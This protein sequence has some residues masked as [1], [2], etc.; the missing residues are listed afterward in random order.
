MKFETQAYFKTMKLKES[1]TMFGLNSKMTKTVKSHFWGDKK[2]SQE[3][4]M[5]T[6][7]SNIENISHIK[8]CPMYSQLREGKDLNN[9]SDLVQ[10]FTEVLKMRENQDC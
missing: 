6:F 8:F 1:R 4:W 5:C 9:D 3:L 10:Y 2:F 7:C